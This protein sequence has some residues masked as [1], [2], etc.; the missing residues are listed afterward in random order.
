MSFFRQVLRP[1]MMRHQTAAVL[2]RHR[3]LIPFPSPN[4]HLASFKQQSASKHE[5]TTGPH[6]GTQASHTAPVLT[7]PVSP[8]TTPRIS[9]DEN[10][11]QSIDRRNRA[12]LKTPDPDKTMLSSWK[13]RSSS[14]P[15]I[16]PSSVKTGSNNSNVGSSQD[17]GYMTPVRKDTLQKLA[18]SLFYIPLTEGECALGFFTRVCMR[19]LAAQWDEDLLAALKDLSGDTQSLDDTWACGFV[20]SC[21]VFRKG[22]NVSPQLPLVSALTGKTFMFDFDNIINYNFSDP[23]ADVAF[24]QLTPLQ[25]WQAQLFEFHFL[26]MNL[27]LTHDVYDS[28]TDSIANGQEVIIAKQLQGSLSEV[29]KHSLKI[30]SKES[31]KESVVENVEELLKSNIL[32]TQNTDETKPKNYEDAVICGAA[33][34]VNRRGELVG[35]SKRKLK[36]T[37]L[38]LPAKMLSGAIA[39]DLSDQVNMSGGQVY[40]PEWMDF[41]INYTDLYD[42]GLLK[43]PLAHNNEDMIDFVDWPYYEVWYERTAPT[44]NLSFVMTEKFWYLRP[45]EEF[46]G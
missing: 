1:V 41:K 19:D 12:I 26:P 34:A 39:T 23:F 6:D 40:R 14:E 7:G 3:S 16:I 35:I 2:K 11:D 38:L 29:I 24:V 30:K 42:L 20:T 44:N 45:E 17:G 10:G 15:L 25:I 9:T 18:R 43:D 22:V 37:E 46:F 5:G 31:S 21:N 8:V 36:D 28:E 33:P 13:R 32:K 27:N 4:H